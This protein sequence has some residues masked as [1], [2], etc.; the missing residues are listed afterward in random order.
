[1]FLG[2]FSN[3]I[4]VI[5]LLVCF[6]QHAQGKV[7]TVNNDGNN[8]TTCCRNGTCLCNSLYEAL[9]Y[10]ESNTTVNITSK[11]VLLEQYVPIY[12]KSLNSVIIRGNNNTMVMCNDKGGVESTSG[13]NILIEGITWDKCGDPIHSALKFNDAYNLSIIGCTFQYSKACE[14][15]VLL[16]TEESEAF[17]FISIINSTFTFNK[18]EDP[19]E[20]LN[21]HGT[22]LI[23][24][25]NT[26]HI[27]NLQFIISRTTFHYNGNQRD[28]PMR[29]D[30]AVGVVLLSFPLHLYAIIEHSIFSSNEVLG[31]SIRSRDTS[32]IV[33]NNITVFNNSKGGIVILSSVDTVFDF[34]LSSFIENKNGGLFL[35]MDNNTVLNFTKISFLRNKGTFDL[36]LSA[37]LYIYANSNTT[38]NLFHCYFDHNIA[39]GGD[40]MVYITNKGTNPSLG[41][42]V[43]VSMCSSSFLNNELGSALHISQVTLKFCSSIL[44]QNNSAES[45]AAIYVDH[46]ALIT[47]MNESFVQFVNNTASLRGGAIYADFTNCFNNGILFCNLSNFSSVVFINNSARVS[48]NSIYFSISKSCNIERDYNKSDSVA[49]IPYKLKYNQSDNIF[50]PAIAASPYRISLC[51]PPHSCS[52]IN[53]NCSITDKK[54][55]GY[56]AYFNATVCDYFDVVT[57]SVQFQIKCTNCDIEYKLLNSELLINNRSPDKVTITSISAHS[58]VVNDTNVA[59]EIVSVLPDNYKQVLAGLSLTLSTCY[60]GFIFYTDSQRCGCYNS[61]SNDIVQC[62][63]DHA[64]IK[65]GYWFG[66]IFQKHTTSLC[67]INYC[68]FHYRTETRRN[69]YSLSRTVDDQ[70][71]SHRTGVVCSDCKPGYTLAYDSFDCVNEDHCSPAI[72]ALVVALTFLYWSLIVIVL[73]ALTYYFSTQVSSGYFNGVI[74]FYSMMDILLASKLYIIDGLFYTVAILSSFAKLT[75]QFLGKLCLAKDLEAIDQQFI[76]YSHTLCI[77][78]ILI[79][80]AI[81]AK[82][83]TKILFYV[84]RCITSIIFLFLVLSY[85]SVTSTSLQLLRGIQ[86]DDND[87]IYAYLSPQFKYFTNRHAAYGTIALLCGLILTIGLPLLLIFKPC[88]CLTKKKIFKY[89]EPSLDQFKNSYKDSYKDGYQWFAANYL[90]CRFVIMLIAYYGNSDYSNMVYY[91]QTA[92]VIFVMN[93]VLLWPYKETLVNVLDTLILLTMV[94]VVNL[95]NVDFSESATA[96]L[97]YTLL[98]TPLVL[99]LG[100]GFSK[101]VVFLKIKYNTTATQ[102][103]TQR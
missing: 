27:I 70:C 65:V 69:Y 57:E 24:H 62:Q 78:F 14:M 102:R 50:G 25:Q 40:G 45:G 13:Y 28:K 21:N 7:I 35:S 80:I 3:M 37:V 85:T 18:L 58:D 75:P 52:N 8:S 64:E 72:T 61:G 71:R 39:T 17:M 97:I 63:Q 73:F 23:R 6:I 68:D 29:K 89:I 93:H 67:P 46:N 15:V 76:H 55:L 87:G 83:S 74:Y 34:M 44:F 103:R 60:N 98:F 100:I 56:P 33:F 16:L 96:G 43:I 88:T 10:I 42:N 49:Y 41:H 26:A 32:K 2:L 99:L 86:N 91:I 22:L 81:A 38:V 66:N 20:C 36:Q 101:L 4:F 30:Q 51:S 90:L 11:S 48:G 53:E 9:L 12:I 84:N 47:V 54:M 59:L 94:L 1:M 31:M 79:C 19:S 82:C 5:I 77:L 95:N 92:C